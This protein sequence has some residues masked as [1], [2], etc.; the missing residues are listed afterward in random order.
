MKQKQLILIAIS[1]GL[2]V[3]ALGAGIY[4]KPQFN[5]EIAITPAAVDNQAIFVRLTT[6]AAKPNA[7]YTLV[8]AAPVAQN[9]A[10]KCSLSQEFV[11]PPPGVSLSV[12]NVPAQNSSSWGY[13]ASWFA[14][15]FNPQYAVI[16]WSP[17]STVSQY[18]LINIDNTSIDTNCAPSVDGGV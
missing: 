8:S 14:A 18:H 9:Q 15:P 11:A 12:A 3:T 5:R 4:L 10:G 1:L 13:L 17:T 16:V 2:L 6:P 7:Q